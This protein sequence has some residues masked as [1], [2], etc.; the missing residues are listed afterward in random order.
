LEL[1]LDT[2]ILI[3]WVDEPKKLPVHLYTTLEDGANSLFISVASAWEMQIKYQ[4]GK[5]KFQQPLP[6]LIANQQQRNGA[7]ILSVTLTH[8]FELGN[9]P[10][11]HKDPFDRLL[12]A[13]AL[14]ENLTL[15]SVDPAFAAY[16]IKLLS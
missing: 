12:I 11:H 1:L 9:L 5:L 3:G 4:L 10:L 13:Q 8:V 7:R 6:Q 15:V 2:H 14:A 16:P